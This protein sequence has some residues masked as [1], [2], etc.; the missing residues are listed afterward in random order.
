MAGEKKVVRVPVAS[1]TVAGCLVSVLKSVVLAW[2]VAECVSEMVICR[3]L[4]VE[5]LTAL[6]EA[7]RESI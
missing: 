2:L 6:G 4:P 7:A 5:V 3:A 1:T